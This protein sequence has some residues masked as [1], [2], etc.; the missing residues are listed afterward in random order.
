MTA[1][2][3][4]RTQHPDCSREKPDRECSSTRVPEFDDACTE[5]SADGTPIEP[6]DADSTLRLWPLTAV[7]S[8]AASAYICL[9]LIGDDTTTENTTMSDDYNPDELPRTDG[10]ELALLSEAEN[11]EDYRDLW[12]RILD[13]EVFQK[14]D[15][16]LTGGE[17]ELDVA[18][19]RTDEAVIGSSKLYIQDTEPADATEGDVWID[20]S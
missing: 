12:G 5:P 18:S 16:K 4:R 14:L 20:T 10:L 6:D 13:N 1:E 9:K 7:S 17:G 3:D 19:V 11:A 8:T 15:S 2:R